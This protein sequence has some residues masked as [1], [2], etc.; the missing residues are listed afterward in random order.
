MTWQYLAIDL[1]G[2]LQTV[3]VNNLC[4]VPVAIKHP[5]PVYYAQFGAALSARDEFVAVREN[6]PPRL[7]R[8]YNVNTQQLV[9]FAPTESL[10][11]ESPLTVAVGNGRVP[12]SGIDAT[13]ARVSVNEDGK[14]K[15]TLPSPTPN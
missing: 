5:Q 4:P 3:S 14:L 12:V 15:V 9:A 11:A 1:V 7:V 2:H 10:F 13:G 6:K 8:V